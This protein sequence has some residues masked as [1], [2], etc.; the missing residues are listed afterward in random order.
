MVAVQRLSGA[1]GE[2]APAAPQ[3]SETTVDVIR[4][5][6]LVRN[7]KNWDEAFRA[8]EHLK[9]MRGYLAGAP[10]ERVSAWRMTCEKTP[11][12]GFRLG[13]TPLNPLPGM[14][15]AAVRVAWNPKRKEY[16][17]LDAS[18]KS[19]LSPAATPGNEHVRVT[20]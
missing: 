18:G 11:D 10:A 13:F 16:D 4:V 15:P 19:F 6:I 8:D 17:S 9:N 7:G 5:S 2:S 12:S 20:H 1:A 3:F 14:K